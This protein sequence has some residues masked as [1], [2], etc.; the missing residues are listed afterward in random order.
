MKTSFNCVYGFECED[1]FLMGV[2]TL[3]K[4]AE[5]FAK[6]PET[7]EQS[8]IPPVVVSQSL[9]EIKDQLLQAK[10]GVLHDAMIRLAGLPGPQCEPLS[11]TVSLYSGA[12]P[13]ATVKKELEQCGRCG[14][15]FPNP[16]SYH[17]SL[18][19]CDII[20]AKRISAL[21]GSLPQL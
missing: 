3:R 2:F 19:E 18:E 6:L 15:Y 4:D 11:D 5:E 8:H 17:H 14:D 13:A 1:F 9:N 12:F 21:S 10:L 7:R 16:V 20:R